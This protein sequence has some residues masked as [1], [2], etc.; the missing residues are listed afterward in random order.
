[1][2]FAIKPLK[3]TAQLVS[4]FALNLIAEPWQISLQAWSKRRVTS[5]RKDTFLW[6]K[7]RQLF[8]ILEPL[9]YPHSRLVLLWGFGV[10]DPQDHVGW[11]GPPDVICSSFP[12]QS[13]RYN[14]SRGTKFLL[15]LEFPSFF[16]RLCFLTGFLLSSLS[17]VLTSHTTN[18][19]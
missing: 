1:M 5:V 17:N 18:K 15:R 3:G 10:V 6:T 9:I 13:L 11:K 8:I 14:F 12:T 16:L 19:F 7:T 4:S 2:D